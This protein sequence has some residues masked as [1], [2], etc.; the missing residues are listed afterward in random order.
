M[1]CALFFKKIH[2]PSGYY[3]SHLPS[4]RSGTSQFK[5]RIV[6]WRDDDV[7]QSEPRPAR[8]DTCCVVRVAAFTVSAVYV[9]RGTAVAHQVVTVCFGTAG[10]TN[11]NMMSK[12]GCLLV[13]NVFY[14]ASI[15]VKRL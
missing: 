15:L 14:L 12:H 7:W 4:V 10:E 11:Y 1:T 9:R 8:D 5:V 3:R 13:I 2:N 6:V